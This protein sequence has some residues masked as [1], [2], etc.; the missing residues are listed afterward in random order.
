MHI[1]LHHVGRKY[2]TLYQCMTPR[3]VTQLRG[4]TTTGFQFLNHS[5]GV[6]DWPLVSQKI[7]KFA[8]AEASSVVKIRGLWE[9]QV[10]FGKTSWSLSLKLTPHSGEKAWG[11]LIWWLERNLTKGSK[12]VRTQR[13][14]NGM[15][16]IP[17]CTTE[18]VEF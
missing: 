3:Q 1:K 11:V 9:S 7:I 12:H 16:F 5:K 13:M 2:L 4:L 6:W 17:A 10:A 14:K 8:S 15:Q 18:E